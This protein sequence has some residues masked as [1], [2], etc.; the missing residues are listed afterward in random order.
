VEKKKLVPVVAV[1][2]CL[3]FALCCMAWAGIE[4]VPWKP[5]VNRLNAIENG[6][7]SIHQR[8]TRLLN[9]PPDAYT[10]SSD[11]NGA[12]GRLQAMENQ[13]ILQNGMLDSVMEEVLQIPP[14]PNAPEALLPALEGVRAASQ[15]IADSINAYLAVPPDP[16]APAF[17]SALTNVQIA[18]QN[19][20]G[21]SVEYIRV[22]GGCLNGTECGC[23]GR[24]TAC[25]AF[26]DPN[27]CGNQLGCY[28]STEPGGGCLGEANS[29]SSITD[30]TV[31]VNQEGCHAGVCVDGNCQ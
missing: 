5:E 12:V 16:Y 15:G 20:A 23:V 4:P 11:V 13:L 17:I 8:V 24:P 14:D 25:I 29:C 22:L 31:C 18:A 26:L 30:L 3:L 1:S 28:W 21:D 10:P 9:I 27:S 6:L 7:R 19:I 2:V